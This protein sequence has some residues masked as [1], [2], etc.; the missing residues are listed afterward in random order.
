M[1]PARAKPPL[2]LAAIQLTSIPL[3][4]APAAAFQTCGIVAWS[5]GRLARREVCLWGARRRDMAAPMPAGAL[6]ARGGDELFS[7]GSSA[8]SD[9]D[10]STPGG[11]SNVAAVAEQSRIR[12]VREELDKDSSGAMAVELDD[13][14]FEQWKQTFGDVIDP[15]QLKKLF[16][17]L[18]TD[19]NKKVSIREFINGLD[20]FHGGTLHPPAVKNVLQSVRLKMLDRIS[21]LIN[22][23]KRK[24]KTPS[25]YILFE[26]PAAG[27]KAYTDYVTYKWNDKEKSRKYRRTVFTD[28]DWK[29][30]R[31]SG[32]SIFHNL[33]TMFNSRI[34]QGLWME[35][36]CV[37]LVA[38]TV[39]TVNVSIL[40]GML[41]HFLSIVG[42]L[43]FVSA[44]GSIWPSFLSFGLIPQ[45]GSLL[46]SLPALPFQLSSPALGL[47][48]VF[49][50]NT[51]YARWNEARLA[52]GSIE[53]HAINL[54][55]QGVSYLDP[56][57]KE[58][59][60]RRVLALAH[61]M[62]AHFRN[63]EE[64]GAAARLKDTLTKLL[65]SREA[66]RVV[67]APNLQVQA[68]TDI[69]LIVRDSQS[70]KLDG[71]TKARFD[72]HLDGLNHALILCDRLKKMPGAF[73]FDRVCSTGY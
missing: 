40:S 58:P 64:D 36:A 9:E 60:I 6:R 43:P 44:L 12:T 19:R 52:W 73:L 7:G 30:F 29:R 18:D 51:A 50:T 21:D 11:A 14:T 35:V 31:S 42:S 37:F 41:Q 32:T 45:D 63:E 27:L 69:S 26:A 62:L 25:K 57:E 8:S 16:D 54:A 56:H 20:G 46:L 33:D 38:L 72:V 39:W 1:M 53:N 13:M 10:G 23:R 66:A 49:R 15:G 47:L 5:G 59:H 24:N 34:I 22:Q 67:Q 48:L 70:P 28:T 55:R 17:Q 4:L 68:M 61:C 2:L 71:S 65:G 3:Q